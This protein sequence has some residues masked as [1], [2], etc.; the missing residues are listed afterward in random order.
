VDRSPE[1]K[2]KKPYSPPRLAVYG[3]IEEIRKSCSGSVRSE[4]ELECSDVLRSSVGREEKPPQSRIT[5][6]ADYP[7]SGRN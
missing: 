4:L 3:T 2:T 6:R 5:F 1:R 7:I